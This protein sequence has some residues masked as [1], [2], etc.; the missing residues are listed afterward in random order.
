MRIDQQNDYTTATFDTSVAISTRVRLFPLVS[1]A[2]E[3]IIP[4]RGFC[5]V[6]MNSSEAV[7]FM[8]MERLRQLTDLLVEMRG[9][10]LV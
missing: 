2:A 1:P 6:S 10:G 4:T 3:V 8:E 7:V 9:R 5:E